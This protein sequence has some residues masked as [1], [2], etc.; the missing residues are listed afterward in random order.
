MLSSPILDYT[1]LYYEQTPDQK[2]TRS[3]IFQLACV[4]AP[5]LPEGVGFRVLGF[6]VYESR[7]V[8]KPHV[9]YSGRPVPLPDA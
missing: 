9:L 5:E 3:F 6:R 2:L 8:E 4:T 7:A 1:L